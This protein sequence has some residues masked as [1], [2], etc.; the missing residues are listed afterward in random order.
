MQTSP[1]QHQSIRSQLSDDY[2]SKSHFIRTFFYLCF[3]LVFTTQLFSQSKTELSEKD[4]SNNPKVFKLSVSASFFYHRQADYKYRLQSNSQPLEYDG[5]KK[6]G[7]MVSTVGLV[8]PLLDKEGSKKAFVNNLYMVFSLPLLDF[9]TN[10]LNLFNKVSVGGLGLGYF[11]GNSYIIAQANYGQIK[12]MS[13]YAYQHQ[14]FP[15]SVYPTLAV[16]AEIPQEFLKPYLDD[17]GI[18]FFSVG[19]ALNF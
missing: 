6:N 12:R 9:Y 10:E 11:I 7:F 5:E 17:V 13:E 4:K 19:V 1:P 8:R 18:W 16:N 15:N 14:Q 3:A 2:F